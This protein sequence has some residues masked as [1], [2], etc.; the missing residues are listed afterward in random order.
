MKK[1]YASLKQE[2]LSAHHKSKNE[3]CQEIGNKKLTTLLLKSYNSE[4]PPPRRPDGGVWRARALAAADAGAEA[5][6]LARECPAWLEDMAAAAAAEFIPRLARPPP[7]AAV[8]PV[9]LPP[10]S[11]RVAARA[12]RWTAVGV[13]PPGTSS[14]PTLLESPAAHLTPPTPPRPRGSVARR[15]APRRARKPQKLSWSPRRSRDGT[16]RAPGP[17]RPGRRRCAGGATAAAGGAGGGRGR[18][19]AGGPPCRRVCEAGRPPRVRD[20][21]SAAAAA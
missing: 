18:G 8:R 3:V 4:P 10:H 14:L 17:S 5:R 11:A 2:L 20:L 7:P 9:P 6:A 12:A 16:L 19:R 1:L 13:F 21:R 15:A